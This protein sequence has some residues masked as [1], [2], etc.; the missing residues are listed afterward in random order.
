MR[1]ITYSSL[2]ENRLG[3]Y[4]DNGIIDLRFGCEQF[5]DPS[6]ASIFTDARTFLTSGRRGLEIANRI[7]DKAMSNETSSGKFG[8]SDSCILH[9]EYKLRPP[10]TNPEKILCPAVNY[11]EHGKESGRDPPAEP[12]LFG[13]FVNTLVGQDDSVYIPKISKMPDY[14]VELAVVMGRRGKHIQIESAY[15]Y[16][17]GYTILNDISFRDLQGWPVNHPKYGPHWA[18]GKGADT[19]CPLGPWI[20]TSDEL[21]MP[22]PLKLKLSVNGVTRQDSD[23]SEQVFKVPELI[24][25]VSQVMTLEPGDI[26]STGTPSGVGRTSGKFLKDGDVMEAEIEKIGIL[27]N[28]VRDEV[29][30]GK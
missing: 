14:E 17:A 21:E 28:K 6:L 11:A 12:Y 3:A 26:I 22:Y 30:A 10:V 5:S 25:Y 9:G 24:S 27:R 8:P 16:V 15:D 1:L 23:T 7:I 19:A 4:T 29:T 2:G 18:M 20:I 13:K